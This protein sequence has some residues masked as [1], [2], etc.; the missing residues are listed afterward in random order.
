MLAVVK[1]P[2]RG[3]DTKILYYAVYMRSG[4]FAANNTPAPKIKP[5]VYY[6]ILQS[7]IWCRNQPSWART[8]V[9]RVGPRLA[10]STVR[11]SR[12]ATR[13]CLKTLCPFYCVVSIETLQ[14]D[15]WLQRLIHRRRN[16]TRNQ[17]Q[18]YILLWSCLRPKISNALLQS[19]SV[20]F[21]SWMMTTP[22]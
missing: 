9:N 6:D 10:T 21:C 16:P 14:M 19:H 18:W 13:I 17:L 8:F 5:D 1:F 7:M 15:L 20:R 11:C 2:R 4:K 22:R 3:L 12:T